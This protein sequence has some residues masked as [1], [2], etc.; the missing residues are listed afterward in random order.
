MPDK[1]KFDWEAY[2]EQLSRNKWLIISGIIAIA[3]TILLIIYELGKA[4][5]H[6]GG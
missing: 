4:S 3:A 1:E 5:G 6:L 2:K